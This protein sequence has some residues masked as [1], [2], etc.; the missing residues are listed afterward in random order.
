MIHAS[1]QGQY[2]GYTSQRCHRHDTLKDAACAVPASELDVCKPVRG[3]TA[4][5]R[6]RLSRTVFSDC[7]NLT[8]ALSAVLAMLRPTRVLGAVK[9]R[10]E[11][12]SFMSTHHPGAQ[13]GTC[14][15]FYR[16][17]LTCFNTLLHYKS[18]TKS[19]GS[20]LSYSL[21]KRPKCEQPMC[22]GWCQYADTT[23]VTLHEAGS[24]LS[25]GIQGARCWPGSASLTLHYTECNVP[26]TAC[27]QEHHKPRSGWRHKQGV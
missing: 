22:T 17:V 25:N 21:A 4:A 8:A 18:Y 20:M 19:K 3:L 1:S 27:H 9:D 16:N 2:S 15:R 10:P 12:R 5:A 6:D 26:P 23:Q 13:S 24:Q 11:N 7:I 14:E